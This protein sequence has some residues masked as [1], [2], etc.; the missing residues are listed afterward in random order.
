MEPSE[1]NVITLHG[2]KQVSVHMAFS[3]RNQKN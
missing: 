3:K 2:L 1:I